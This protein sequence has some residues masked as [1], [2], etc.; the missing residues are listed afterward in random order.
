MVH[1]V[2]GVGVDARAL[3]GAGL[4]RARPA[5]DLGCCCSRVDVVADM[6]LPAGVGAIE[7]LEGA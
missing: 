6:G 5:L 1:V 3:P 7:E 2:A 4:V